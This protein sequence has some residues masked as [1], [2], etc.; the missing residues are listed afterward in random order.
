[1]IEALHN[2]IIQYG[3]EMA[4]TVLESFFEDGTKSMNPHG[5][6]IFVYTKEK[7]LDCF[8]FCASY[9]KKRRRESGRNGL[10]QSGR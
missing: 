3:A 2:E 8:L 7:A 6:K 4:V 9:Q 5:G 10:G 1:M